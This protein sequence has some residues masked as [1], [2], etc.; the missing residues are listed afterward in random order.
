MP[1]ASTQSMSLEMFMQSRLV[2]QTPATRIYDA[3]RAME[4]NHI[5][6]VLVGEAHELV[7]IVTD[8][9][10]ALKVVADGLDPL[11]FQL[12]DIMSAPVA[13]VPASATVAEVAE[14]MTARH[15]R[16][17]PILNGTAVAGIVTL[18]DLALARAVDSFTLAGILR[19]QLSEPAKLKPKGKLYPTRPV[20]GSVDAVRERA[21]RRHEA[22]R[23]RA[24]IEL[25]RRTLELTGLSF[26]EQAESALEV[27]LSGLVRR[28]TPE[29]A[30]DFLSQLPSR[31]RQ[32]ALTLPSGPD[33]SVTRASI[34]HELDLYLGVGPDRAA[35]ILEGTGQALEQSISAG[36]IEDLRS[37]LPSDL[38]QLFSAPPA[39]TTPAAVSMS[40]G[41]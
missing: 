14:L 29:E 26:A 7:G 16:R 28:V 33:P 17:V 22:Q 30:G 3:V 4:D 41:S 32:Y 25:L 38:K 13:S 6:A 27:V 21:V 18:D 1:I 2:V 8:R 36:E 11:E 12:S 10:V 15:V 34:E 40:Q 23:H 35:E 9:D 20:Q 24:Y 37:Q 39:F 5:G 31:V 19:A